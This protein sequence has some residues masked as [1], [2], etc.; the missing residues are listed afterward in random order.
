MRA[1][2]TWRPLCALDSSV[3]DAAI[4]LV[5]DVRGMTPTVP[6]PVWRKPCIWRIAR[7][8][9]VERLLGTT[10]GQ[11]CGDLPRQAGFASSSPGRGHAVG[12]RPR[13]RRQRNCCFAGILW[14]VPG[15]NRVR[16]AKPDTACPGLVGDYPREHG[17]SCVI[18]GDY[19]ARSGHFGD[20][21][22]DVR[23]MSPL[24]HWE[25]PR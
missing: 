15:S 20:L 23:G 7:G 18:R 4:D 8:R 3:C 24:A 19:R 22:R 10:G 12:S 1:P 11:A 16:L 6:L 2:A 9:S 17:F 5:R 25:T 13:L 21:V 14:S